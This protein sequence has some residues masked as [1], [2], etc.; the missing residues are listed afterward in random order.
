VTIG[1]ADGTE[2]AHSHRTFPEGLRP[3]VEKKDA[4]AEEKK[5]PGDGKIPPGF[6]PQPGFPGGGQGAG[7]NVG[8]LAHGLWKDRYS[9]VSEQSRKIP[10]AVALIVD[11]D[12]V[13]R[14]LT[15]F[16]N[17]HLRF[18]ETQVLVNHYPLP[19]QP[20]PPEDLEGGGPM[21]PGMP[22]P[23]FGPGKSGF[24]PPFGGMPKGFGGF[25]GIGPGDPTGGTGQPSAGSD[26]E[27]N[28][29]L[30]IYGFMTLYQRYPP[31]TA[32]KKE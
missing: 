12:H 29:E 13:D 31:P 8:A 15:A 2:I 22:P 20:P 5:G 28:M 25:G 23:S 9:E 7:G 18:L 11:Q 24:P 27:S 10:I 32:A 1:S 26:L 6:N 21:S 19:L 30:V 14:V 3:L 4:P 16:N 17:S